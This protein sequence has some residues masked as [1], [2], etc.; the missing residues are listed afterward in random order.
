MR[1]IR[2]LIVIALVVSFM[3]LEAFCNEHHHGEDEHHHGIVMCQ[4]SCH[5]AVLTS[6]EALDLPEITEPYFSIQDFSYEDPTLPADLR[7]PI[8]VS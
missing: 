1:F 4:G 3:P 7:P 5:G 8:F 2:I 6:M